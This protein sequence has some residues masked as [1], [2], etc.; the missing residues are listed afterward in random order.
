MQS[1]SSTIPPP[2]TPPIPSTLLRLALL[3]SCFVY[4]LIIPLYILPM[5]QSGWMLLTVYCTVEA[6]IKGCSQGIETNGDRSSVVLLAL[7]CLSSSFS[8]VRITTEAL[9]YMRFV[10]SLYDLRHISSRIAAFT[11]TLS[12]SLKP[13][14]EVLSFLAVVTV[15]LEVANSLFYDHFTGLQTVSFLSQYVFRT[16]GEASPPPSEEPS[17][18]SP[19]SASLIYGF[20]MLFILRGFGESLLTIIQKVS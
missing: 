2:L 13:N 7:I 9:L 20:L 17:S 6:I 5:P 14:V 8:P 1:P 16:G 11:D 12:C 18:S 19:S 10:E 3:L 15:I 4:G